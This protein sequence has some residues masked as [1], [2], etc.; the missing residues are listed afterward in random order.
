MAN[1]NKW[2]K[3]PEDH[4]SGDN[5]GMIDGTEN[6]MRIDQMRFKIK[7]R[8]KGFSICGTI[9]KSNK[10]F[11]SSRNNQ[12]KFPDLNH[13]FGLIKLIPHNAFTRFY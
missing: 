11:H 7:K 12:L 3:I 4:T 13:L 2:L 5:E 8:R 9:H 10:N 6:I 1:R